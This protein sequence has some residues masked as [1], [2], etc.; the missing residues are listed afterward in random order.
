MSKYQVLCITLLALTLTLA[1]C[2]SSPSSSSSTP[3][4]QV[5]VALSQ[6]SA[7]VTV[8]GTMQFTATVQGTTN[9]SVTWSVD[10]VVGGNATAGTITTNGVYSAPAQAGTH[11]VTAT[12]VADPTKTATAQ[13]TVTA[14]SGSVTVS[15]SP[16][17]ASVSTGATAQFTATVNGTTSTAVTWS[18]DSVNGGSST[19]GT[20]NATGL[21]TA[22]AQA[23]SHTVKATSNQDATKSAT[24]TVTVSSGVSP[25]VSPASA[26]VA[27]SGTQQ[28]T[29]NVSVN[30]SVD[31]VNG[32]NSAVGTI[33]MSG[34]YKAPA[35][36]G[37]HAITGTSTVNVSL[38]ATSYVTVINA[39]QAAV[40]TYH[41]TDNRD[42]A[43]LEE[44]SL[45]PSNVNANQFGKIVSYPVDGQIY[46]QPL[47]V[48]QVNIPNQG[49]R[50]VVYVVT[51]ND[52]VYAFDA[53]A[54][55]AQPTTLW[56]DYF[57]PPVSAHDAEGPWPEVGILSTPVID[58]TTNI[59][60]LVVESSHTGTNASPFWL[61]AIDIT[62][63][64]ERIGHISITASVAGTGWDSVGGQISLETSCYQRMALA[65]DPVTNQIYIPFGSCNHGWILAYDKSTLA[66]KSVFNDTPDGAGGGLWAG[67]GGIAIDDTNGD[68]LFMS[69]TDTGD[70][71]FITGSTQSG[72]ND[73]FIRL[74]PTNLSVLSYFSP[75]DNFTLAVNDADLGSG[76]NILVPGNSQSPKELVGGGK[77]GNVYV[78]NPVNMGGFNQSSNTVLQ[79]IKMGVTQYNNIFSTPVYWNG[80]IYFHCNADVIRAFSWNA[81]AAAGQQ[82]STQP[83][84]SG[85]AVFNM[86]GAT[87]SLSSNGTSNAIIWDIDDSAYVGDDPSNSGVAVLHAY[88]ATNLAVELYNSAQAGSRDVAG[89]AGKFTVPTIGGGKVFVPTTTE[90]DIYG[91][92]P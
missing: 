66:Q 50:D 64:A 75:D 89:R 17:S 60:Y 6:A 91:L 23:G 16:K 73:A 51:Q 8:S 15:V 46:A 65:L 26:T 69:G 40:L 55:A 77:D 44:L 21:Y 83:T 71:Q 34:L 54:T 86:H 13:V 22:P 56:H 30:W 81:G 33:S 19:A 25:T 37:P 68:L 41:N 88:D 20:I 3:G 28:F 32:G 2:G 49:K 92:L 27:P 5:H 45:K 7:T 11:T 10:S 53:D 18:V 36:I 14:A 90:L 42:G 58:A 38:S 43:Y 52:S 63:G 39:S 1:G 59:M 79:N 87:A 48:P 29:S 47:Y 78:N 57:G 4:T 74:D 35:A 72:Y 80:S 85:N 12:S 24:A 84:S 82:M 9:A 61:Y 76:A 70:E 62:T 67:G 31:G